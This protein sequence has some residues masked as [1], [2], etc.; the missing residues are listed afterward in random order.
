[1]WENIAREFPVTWK[2]RRD[3]LPAV[4]V[5]GSGVTQCIIMERLRRRPASELADL[6]IVVAADHFVIFGESHRLPWASGGLYLGTDP[7]APGLLLPTSLE[8]T[9]PIHL[10]ED[11][12]RARYTTHGAQ[13]AVFPKPLSLV[14]ITNA[15]PVSDESV[16]AWLWNGRR[17][18]PAPIGV[19]A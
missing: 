13:L 5:A 18:A 1:M 19:A 12:L 11:V 16:L 4:A 3:P 15:K 10:F 6:K 14:A 17:H 7:R 2:S 9:L 8:P